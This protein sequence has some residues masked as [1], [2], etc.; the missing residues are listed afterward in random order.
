MRA[1]VILEQCWHRVPGGT[2]TA[3]L[4]QVAAL[5]ATGRRRP[6]RR[7][8]PPPAPPPAPCRPTIPVR[9]LPLPRQA[10]YETWHRC[11]ARRS[12]GPPARSTSSTPPARHP[13]PHGARSSSRSTTSPGGR[14]P[15]M[16]TRHG[17]RFFEAGLALRARRRRPRAVPVAGDARGLRRRRLRRDAPAPRA[18]GRRP[19][20]TSPTPRSRP[21]ARAV[22]PHRALRAVGRAPSSPART[23]PRLVEAFARLP[24]RDVDAR[25]RR[26]P[27]AG[28]TRRHRGHA[29]GDAAAAHGLRPQRRARASLRWG[30][31]GRYPSLRE[32]FGLP[33]LE[34]MAQGAPV[35]TSAGTA[36]EELVAGGAGLPSTRTTSTPSP[37]RIASVLDDDDLADRLRAAGRER[38]AST[39]W[40][41]TAAATL[42]A[43]EE[44]LGSVR[45]GCNLLWLVPGSVGGTETATVALAARD[46][47]GSARRRRADALRARLVRPD[48]PRRGRGVPDPPGAPRPGASGA[49][50][51]R[52]RTTWL[53]RQATGEVDLVHHIGGVLPP[54]QG[55]PGLV[56]IHDLQPFDMP[57]NFTPVKRAY[58]HRSLPR[59]VRR[60]RRAS[61]RPASSC[62]SGI[63]DRFGIARDRVGLAPCGVEAPE[64]RRERRPGPGPVRAAAAGG[65]CSRRSRGPT[66]TTPCCCGP[67]PRWPPASTTSCSC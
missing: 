51:W 66:R 52:P 60:A 14:D 37:A 19:R 36:T 13:A 2:A 49:C 40:A 1:A 44:V 17:V 46:R 41:G 62:A 3:T 18:L 34:A 42:A 8:R 59:S 65:S 15:S 61:S 11:A 67:S 6:G 24:Q 35:V 58:L 25:A 26:A 27:R 29:A 50:G 9:H 5:A 38:A 21:C 10:L 45:V 53:A 20:S 39:T 63:V 28:A 16:F 48:L 32:G 33:V 47:G 43:Y 22:R 30:G 31:G 56:T 55:A 23:C 57:E 4:G 54:V 12:S 64:H 7:R